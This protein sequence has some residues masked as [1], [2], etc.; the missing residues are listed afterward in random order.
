MG[1]VDQI[2]KEV[3]GSMRIEGME[4][5]EENK[6]NIRICLSDSSRY[7]EIKQSLIAKYSHQY[8]V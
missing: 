7:E 3:D 2:I 6:D 5:T 4:L 1:N 8:Q